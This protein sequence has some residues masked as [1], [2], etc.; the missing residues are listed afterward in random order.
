[1]TTVAP[2]SSCKYQ[3]AYE[4]SLQRGK[5]V[6]FALKTSSDSGSF[7]KVV[8]LPA[9]PPQLMSSFVSFA[10]FSTS[11]MSSMITMEYF[12]DTFDTSG[13]LNT[14]IIVTMILI[15]LLVF[16]E[17]TQVVTTTKMTL[18]R[19]FRAGFSHLSTILLIIFI[20]MVYTQV[21]M[22]TAT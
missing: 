22:I 19:G 14:G 6:N 17:L 7:N 1:M 13:G 9:Y 10:T 3:Y 12:T 18:T 8:S 11:V 2:G 20:G 16:L 21:V 4:N 5:Q 15:S